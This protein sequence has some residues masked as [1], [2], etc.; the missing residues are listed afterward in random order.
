MPY[1]VGAVPKQG[2]A[3]GLAMREFGS[4]KRWFTVTQAANLLRESFAEDITDS[5]VLDHVYAGQIPVWWDATARYAIPVARGCHCFGAHPDPSLA[6]MGRQR[7]GAERELWFHQSE[8]VQLLE[9]VYRIAFD[10]RRDR[11]EIFDGDRLGK[12][13]FTDGILL[14]DQDN[15]SLLQVLRRMPSRPAGSNSVR[16]FIVDLEFPS[17][18]TFRIS[19]ADLRSLLNDDRTGT[20]A[21]VPSDLGDRE[22]TSLHKQIGALAL[23]LASASNRYRK[24]D[25]PNSSRIAEAV[26][27]ILDALPDAKRQGTG[28]SSIRAS[29]KAGLDLLSEA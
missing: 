2:F 22:R 13:E 3:A 25:D 11:Q 8:R 4:F 21:S 19:S 6:G 24:G 5:D 17:P 1:P 18:D 9:G 14:L 12:I 27:D 28:S 15:D 7:S 23:A 16:D 26:T 29:I 10:A 20:D